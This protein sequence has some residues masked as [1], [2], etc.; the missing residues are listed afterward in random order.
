MRFTASSVC[1][2][3]LRSLSLANG[4]RMWQDSIG[5]HDG[6]HCTASEGVPSL[7]NFIIL[8]LMFEQE[9]GGAEGKVA[10]LGTQI[11]YHLF[12]RTRS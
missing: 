8:W 3:H 1:P 2:N 11:I 5:T 12:S 9:M 4:V 10:Y 7:Q 6:G